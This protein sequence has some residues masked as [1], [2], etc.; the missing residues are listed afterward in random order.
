MTT[1]VSKQ[2]AIAKSL[3]AV[4]GKEAAKQAIEMTRGATGKSIKTEEAIWF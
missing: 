2:T 1:I 4:L 3:E